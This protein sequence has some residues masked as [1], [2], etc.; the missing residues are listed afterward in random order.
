MRALS[1]LSVIA[2]TSIRQKELGDIAKIH[3][4]PEKE[5]VARRKRGEGR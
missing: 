3:L 2:S 4:I 1:S 5:T